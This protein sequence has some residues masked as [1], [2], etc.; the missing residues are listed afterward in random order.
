MKQP[1]FSERPVAVVLTRAEECVGTKVLSELDDD[2]TGLN[3][4]LHP[5]PNRHR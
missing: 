1:A 5:V 4:E 2:V 3:A